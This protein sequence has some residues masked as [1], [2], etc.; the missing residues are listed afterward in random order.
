MRRCHFADLG[1]WSDNIKTGFKEVGYEDV[2]WI[3][4]WRVENKGGFL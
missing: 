1:V 4:W 3:E 2:N